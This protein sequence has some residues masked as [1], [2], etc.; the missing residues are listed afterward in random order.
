M[1]LGN[2]SLLSCGCTYNYDNNAVS[3]N[4]QIR[5]IIIMYI[6]VISTCLTALQG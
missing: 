2:V 6:K 5:C 1:Y 4:A 3:I